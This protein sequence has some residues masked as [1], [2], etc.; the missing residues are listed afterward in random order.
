M[1]VEG[2]VAHSPRHSALFTGSRGLV[3]LAL[4]AC[5]GVQERTQSLLALYP[6]LPRTCENKQGLQVGC[7][8]EKANR[9]WLLIRLGCQ[10]QIKANNLLS[11]YYQ[12]QFAYCTGQP[13]STNLQ[14]SV[15][16]LIARLI[17]NRASVKHLQRTI[18]SE[19]KVNQ[20]VHV[21]RLQS[22]C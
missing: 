20:H 9:Q 21:Q 6:G 15:L 13:L 14:T 3:R 4:Y 16:R 10:N 19:S 18:S 17:C 5:M 12:L 2:V 1:E 8:Q 7:P 22:P 11:F